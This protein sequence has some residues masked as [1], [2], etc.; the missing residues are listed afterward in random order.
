MTGRQAGTVAP[1]RVLAA[2]L[3]LQTVF[4][5]PALAQLDPLLFLERSQPNV[6]LVVDVSERM[7]RDANEDYYD[8]FVYPKTGNA[9]ETSLGLNTANMS[10]RYRRK[11]AGFRFA[12]PAAGI[13]RFTATAI[14]AVGDLAPDYA[15]FG[16]RTRLAIARAAL[17]RALLYNR[18]KA[19]FGL[20]KTRQLNP[21]LGTERNDGYVNSPVPAPELPTDGLPGG[22]WKITRP[23]VDAANGSNAAVTAPL[24]R[25]DAATANTDVLSILSREP[26]QAGALVPAGRDSI[27]AIDSPVETMLIDARAEA[28]RL[29]AADTTCRNTIVVLVVG[30]SEGN[31]STAR[32]PAG[33]A[34]TFL[35]ISGR[36]VPIYVVAIA[37]GINDD[38]N[39]LRAIARNSG[40]QYIE[41]TRAM[42]EAAPAGGTVPEVVRAVNLAV[43][44]ALALPVDFNAAPTALLPFGPSSEFQVASPIVGTVDLEGATDINGS[45]LP[46]TVITS[47]TTG[48]VIPQR[49]NVMVTS[50]VA[51]PGSIDTPGFPSVLRAFRVYRPERDASKHTGYKFVQDG[52]PLWVASTPSPALRNIYTVV[53]STDASPCDARTMTVVPFTE[54]NAD[55]LEEYLRVSDPETL[56]SFIRSQ[57]L[58]AVLDSTPAILDPPSLDPPPDGDYP[59]FVQ[60]NRE[61]R[62]LVLVGANDGMLHAIDGRLGQ[63]VWAFIPFNLL[64]KLRSL[65]EGQPAGEFR[66]F[67]DSSPKIAD[68]KVDGEWKTHVIFGQGPGGTF[69]QALDFTLDRMG[70]T[71]HPTDSL[72]S[73]LSYFSNPDR[74]PVVWSFPCYAHFDWT[75]GEFGELGDTRWGSATEIEKTVGET[76]S[77]PAVGQVQNEDGPFV[78]LA[79]SGFFSYTRQL[80]RFPSGA[81]AVGTT[82]YVIA[83]GT[84]E[85][86]ASEDVGSDG[87]AETVDS[88]RA[89]NNCTRIKNALQSDPVATGP[90]NSRFVNTVYLGDL[91]GRLWR[92]RLGLDASNQAVVTNGPTKLH[93]ATAAHPLFTSLAVVNVGGT[94]QYVFFGTGSDLLPSNGVSQSYKLLGVL[95]SGGPAGS[96]AMSYLLEK[97]EGTGGDEKVSSFPAVAGD[98]VFFTTTTFKPTQGCA[99]PDGNAY[100][101]TFVG[102]AAYDSNGDD[103][104][105]KKDSPKLGTFLGSG[106]ATAPFIVDQHLSIGI[107]GKVEMF[108]D[109]EDFNNGVGQVSVRTLA[110]RERR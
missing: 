84:G 68:V 37:P 73:V 39:Q 51:V 52:T 31:T 71:V 54:D 65:R 13:V 110:W 69:Y 28:A 41:I 86:L 91:D 63:E 98:I 96:L 15:Q 42:I 25:A 83:A 26:H 21:R 5:A 67:V 104:I 90:P 77:D 89:A 11:Y 97:T 23:L 18:S 36:R 29:I 49:S 107:G 22:L 30:G 53:P 103:R 108:G 70:D 3:F 95:D 2:A 9:W 60:A 16:S 55:E 40:G 57:P 74:V 27:T 10:A 81:Q 82:F 61:R 80:A 76:W 43:Q 85:V 99:L 6:L 94:Q 12:D 87:L 50:S 102:G 78:V 38:V 92:F 35:A 58:G 66:F 64:P 72:G 32:D 47:P 62:S 24:V 20:L 1:G 17:T 101:F 79:G 19:R 109:P 75:N 45:T 46:D 14:Q 93:D 56:I 44:H 7:Q 106:R 4:A 8:Q 105:T 48:S 33:R 88:C 34:S 100:A 59:A